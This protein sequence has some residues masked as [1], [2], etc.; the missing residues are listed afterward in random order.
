MYV[1]GGP[2]IWERPT[3]GPETGLCNLVDVLSVELNPGFPLATDTTGWS[4]GVTAFVQ[5]IVPAASICLSS[6]QTEGSMSLQLVRLPCPSLPS[7]ALHV[8]Q[9]QSRKFH[10]ESVFKGSHRSYSGYSAPCLKVQRWERQH[11]S[12]NQSPPHFPVKSA[13]G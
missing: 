10:F 5:Q 2:R 6:K 7:G 12:H 4:A 9:R 3:K 8:R 11:E 1:L 13:P